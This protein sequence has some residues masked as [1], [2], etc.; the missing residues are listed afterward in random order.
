[1][2]RQPGESTAEYLGRTLDEI[3]L[4]DMA[5]RA[6]AF[7]FD[8]YFCPDEIDDGAN[9][10]RLVAE[11]RRRADVYEWADQPRR[12]IEAVIAAAI[13]GE[14]DGTTEEAD[15][16]AASSDGQAIFRDLLGGVDE[17]NR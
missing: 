17:A 8:D 15:A 7:H 10:N 9:I 3:G 14:F 6:R 11:L 2:P 5:L 1:M 12:R 13:D 4:P 16:W